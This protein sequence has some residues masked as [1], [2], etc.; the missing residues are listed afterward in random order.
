MPWPVIAGL[1]FGAL[2]SWLGRRNQSSEG[3]KDRAHEMELQN[4]RF[5]QDLQLAGDSNQMNSDQYN[6]MYGS[7][8][9]APGREAGGIH[10]G[11]DPDAYRE[12]MYGNEPMMDD[13]DEDE[14]SWLNS[15]RY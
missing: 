1:G 4:R 5:D 14:F 9:N 6:W 13:E 11:F 15:G 2:N 12:Q 8:T 3:E 10:P 7:Q